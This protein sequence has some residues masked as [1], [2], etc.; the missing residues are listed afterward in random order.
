MSNVP[1]QSAPTKKAKPH[2]RRAV[3]RG[4]GVVMP[5]LLTIVLFIWAWTTIDGYVLRPIENLV[6]WTA[7][8]IKADVKSEVPSGTEPDMV[9]VVDN[10]G[11]RVPTGDRRTVFG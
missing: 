5:P 8:S 3:L 1:E 7:A 10:Q 6:A 11:Q 2:F 9:V 4:L